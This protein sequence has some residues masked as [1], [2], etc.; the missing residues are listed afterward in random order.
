MAKSKK[1]DIFNALLAELHQKYIELYAEK[2]LSEEDYNF[3]M[4]FEKV[5][6]NKDI[7]AF[8][9]SYDKTAVINKDPE[10][11]PL[12][13]TF[14]EYFPRLYSLGIVNK[15]EAKKFATE[16]PALNKIFN[17]LNDENISEDLDNILKNPSV[18]ELVNNL[19][20]ELTKN[21][22][23]LGSVMNLMGNLGGMGGLGKK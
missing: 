8:T 20:N 17:S 6:F 19:Q 1:V 7:V 12:E 2:K 22:K 23:L 5:K 10:V 16:E 3:V 15:N 21:P 11:F 14:W 18:S 4:K 9:K 13:E